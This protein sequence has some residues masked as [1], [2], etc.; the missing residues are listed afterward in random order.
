MHRK[1]TGQKYTKTLTVIYLRVVGFG[2]NY[3]LNYFRH[4]SNFAQ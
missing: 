3:F 1:N 2:V 4:F